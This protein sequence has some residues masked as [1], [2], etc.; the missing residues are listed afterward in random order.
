MCEWLHTGEKSLNVYVARE[1]CPILPIDTYRRETIFLHEWIHTGEKPLNVYVERE[2][3]P[4]LPMDTY[5]RET[6]F[7]INGYIQERSHRFHKC[8]HIDKTLFIILLFDSVQLF[9]M[10]SSHCLKYS[11]YTFWR[12]ATLSSIFIMYCIILT[13][14]KLHYLR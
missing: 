12:K 9:H 14:E 4:I 5:R 11:L 6:I 10:Y 1:S 2:S 13:G 8:I 7:F 3:C